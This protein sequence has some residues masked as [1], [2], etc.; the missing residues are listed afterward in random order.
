MA[1]PNYKY[2]VNLTFK[3][4]FCNHFCDSFDDASEEIEEVE[5]CLDYPNVYGTNYL[6]TW[7][8][9][10][11]RKIEEYSSLSLDKI[12]REDASIKEIK[13]DIFNTSEN[14]HKY[15]TLSQDDSFDLP[16]LIKD[17]YPN[18]MKDAY[19]ASTKLKKLLSFYTTL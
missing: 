12:G 3:I 8:N 4:K 17:A 18:F 5:T 11:N 19:L 2:I 9:D 13:I 1:Q 7:E 6:D 10:K 14:V 15:E 16:N